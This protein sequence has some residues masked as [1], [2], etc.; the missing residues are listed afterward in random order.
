MVLIQ[1]FDPEF[2]EERGWNPQAK[3]L[4]KNAYLHVTLDQ[5]DW[6]LSPTHFQVSSFPE[7]YR[8]RFSV[9]HDGVDLHRAVPNT[10][11]APLKLPDATVLEFGQPIVTFVNR[12]L[13]PYRGCHTFLR[14]IPEL[15]KC[16]PE[17]RIVIV[18]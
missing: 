2:Q 1:V 17:A 11:P 6:N 16:Y 13:E 10:S 7:H 9:I 15:Q 12:T 14:S 3:I 18:G 5:A 8:R 4:M